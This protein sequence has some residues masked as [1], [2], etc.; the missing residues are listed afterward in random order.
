MAIDRCRSLEIPCDPSISLRLRSILTKE[1]LRLL[2]TTST[3]Q[4]SADLQ[5]NPPDRLC[6]N[7]RFEH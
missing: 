1:Y 2:G 5:H 7:K 4:P 3:E 6:V